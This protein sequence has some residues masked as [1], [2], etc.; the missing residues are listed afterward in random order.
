MGGSRRYCLGQGKARSQ[1]AAEAYL[2]QLVHQ[3]CSIG[4]VWVLGL[5]TDTPA[6]QKHSGVFRR[7]QLAVCPAGDR[8]AKPVELWMIENVVSIRAEG[9]STPLFHRNIPP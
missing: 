9:E 2:R 1:T 8:R 6:D 7:R 4:Y 5:K 3:S